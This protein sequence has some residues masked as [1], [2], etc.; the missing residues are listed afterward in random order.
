[1]PRVG[2]LP[3]DQNPAFPAPTVSDKRE[4]QREYERFLAGLDLRELGKVF[5]QDL[6][7]RAG[8]K[9]GPNRRGRSPGKAIQDLR[10]I[11]TESGLTQP[12][13]AEKYGLSI[14]TIQRIEA[15]R[16]VSQDT[17][18]KLGSLA[19]GICAPCPKHVRK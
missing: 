9:V 10:T 7:D 19:T 16:R 17:L 8:V 12:L 18:K 11:R 4:D 14:S 6:A 5:R 2:I 15:G 3:G 1:M 13:F